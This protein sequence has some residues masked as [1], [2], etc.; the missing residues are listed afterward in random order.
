MPPRTKPRTKMPSLSADGRAGER[1]EKGGS[2]KIGPRP[3]FR[4]FSLLEVNGER[5][6]G[7]MRNGVEKK[8]TPACIGSEKKNG[9]EYE[10]SLPGAYNVW[11]TDRLRGTLLRKS[12]RTLSEKASLLRSSGG[13]KK[14]AK[15]KGKK[16][17]A[18]ENASRF[19]GV[20][21]M[22]QKPKR[23]LAMNEKKDPESNGRT[24]GVGETSFE[25]GGEGPGLA[26]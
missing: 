5:A 23:G 25:G 16:R 13:G 8:T 14:V 2:R 17:R 24:L 11:N 12:R 18:V 20:C 1:K 9:R 15:R 6:T 19:S 3:A 10:L 7:C 4:N 22:K 21:I 26:S